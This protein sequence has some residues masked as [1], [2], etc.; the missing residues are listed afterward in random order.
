LLEASYGKEAEADQRAFALWGELVA[1]RQERDVAEEKIL[2]LSTE[3]A[4]AN[5][6]REAAEE[7]CRHLAQELTFLSIMGSE[8]SITV[9]SSSSRAPLHE[10]MRF[11][12][13]RHTEVASQF[14]TIPAAVS[15]AAQ[16][17]ISH[18][19]MDVP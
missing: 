1:S 13:A 6:P 3:V 4:V 12:V 18:L 15:L 9:T 14:S 19:P 10:G 17:I 8:L 16:S 11:V 5:Q 2:S 7:W